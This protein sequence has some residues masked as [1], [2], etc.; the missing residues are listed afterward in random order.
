MSSISLASADKALKSFYL[1]VLTQ[2]L[3]TNTN[4]LYTKIKATSN[5]VYGKDV[6]KPICF[7]INGGISA[8]TETGNLP[9]AAG[10]Q[11]LQLTASLKN[12][13]G[14]IEITDKAIRA[15][16]NSKG[17]VVNLLN[18]EMEGLLSAAKYNF[19][20]MLYGDGSGV[21]AKITIAAANDSV[22]TVASAANLVEGMVVNI[23]DATAT[24]VKATQRIVYILEDETGF[25]VGLDYL[26]NAD[27]DDVIVIQDSAGNELT[28]LK[29]AFRL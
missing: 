25:K 21:L 5:F 7:G 22:V 1:D 24:T 27:I 9:T 29:A 12:L 26:V 18:A 19:S 16:E 17:A 14:A 11:Y 15:S 28:G 6:R 10:N 23:M 2:Q 20:R 13:Y 4:P 3:N 8:G